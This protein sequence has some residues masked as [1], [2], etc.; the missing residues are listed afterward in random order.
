M[1]AEEQSASADTSAQRPDG[2]HTIVRLPFAGRVYAMAMVAILVSVTLPP[3]RQELMG[4]ILGVG[5]TYPW[6][7]Y[8][9]AKYSGHS[10]T[11]GYLAFSLDGMLAGAAIVLCGYAFVPSAVIATMLVASAVVIGGGN[12][13]VQTILPA[14]IVT[15]LA[16]PHVEADFQAH[17]DGL[18]LYLGAATIGIFLLYFA[19][20]TNRISNRLISAKRS[21]QD[22]N[23]KIDSQARLLASMNQVARVVNSTLD[24][25]RVM[26]AIRE[27]L[28]DV[29]EFDQ[30][31]LL[32]VDPA[33]ENLILDRYVGAGTDVASP[34]LQGLAIPLSETD[35]IFVRTVLNNKPYF[36]A[37]TRAERADMSRTDAMIHDMLPSKSLITLPLSIG[38]EIIGV[39]AF[40]NT[41]KIV[42]AGEDEIEAIERHVGFIATAIRNAR[43]YEKI[44][45]AEKAANAANQAKSQFLANMS[46]ELR[47]PMNAVIG[48][49]EMLKEEAE[50]QGAQDFI[51]D[52]DRIC[53]ASKHLLHLI[54][55]ILDLSK[56]EADKIE[57]YPEP[58]DIEEFIEEISS[59]IGPIMEANGNILEI[60]RK[61]DVTEI[62][63]DVTRLR[64]V[65]LNLISN[66]AKFT[67]EGTVRLTVSS[68]SEDGTGW[69]DIE[70]SDT[71][72]GMSPEQIQQ[73]FQP[74]TQADASTTR[75]YGGTGLGLAISKSYCEMMG[76]TIT[77]GS[78]QGKGSTFTVHIPANLEL[79]PSDPNA[80]QAETATG[81]PESL[82]AS[83]GKGA[84]VLVID[85]DSSA[86]DLL[87]RLLEREGYRVY[88]SDRGKSGLDMAREVRPDVIT[89]DALMPEMDGWTVLG[90]L[91]QDLELSHIPV[92]MISFV[93]EP[94][95]GLALGAAEYITKPVKRNQ[96]LD[97]LA[98]LDKTADTEV[99]VVEDDDDT[100]NLICN[101]L[102]NEG[103]NAHCA[104]NG[105]EGLELFRELRPSVVLLDLMMPEVDGFEF[106][107]TLRCEFPDDD[108]S[109]IVIT[110]KELFPE[111]IE[112]LN[113]SVEKIIEKAQAPGR[114]LLGEIARHL[115]KQRTTT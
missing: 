71:G 51:P 42:N 45:S 78:E 73:V 113:G 79:A 27:N 44:K 35:S 11:V 89:L 72:I 69:L 20:L 77:V 2:V 16:W 5:L 88:T 39:L 43:M 8:M 29:I 6:L 63:S 56:V 65:V 83:A 61:Q 37:D 107:G 26:T 108:S 53:K 9:A 32:F 81:R 1:T 101:W 31:G 34:Q 90:A 40:A 98:R 66:A 112:R 76:G 106:L 28:S 80:A 97:I 46:H 12:L 85:D 104:V 55:D 74:F 24:L 33:R 14:I 54:N 49:S 75:K 84:V 23:R 100:R 58:I 67:R 94:G 13:L 103:W 96:L 52:L 36:L 92:V 64:Q 25:G 50:D 110:A 105:R 82:Q 60:V 114:Q 15:A 87:R 18:P 95:K 57:L 3:D 99:L 109:V 47:T 62:V 59:G 91:K 17:S 70:V 7:I 21:L 102:E 30:E 22:H 48:Y 68:K 38:E 4:I 111:D 93:D 115:E 86:R 41:S 10:K 19:Y